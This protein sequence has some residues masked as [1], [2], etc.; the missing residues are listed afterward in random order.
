MNLEEAKQLCLLH[1]ENHGLFEHGFDFKWI[2]SKK[3]FGQCSTVRNRLTKEFVKGRCFIKLSPYLVELNSEEEVEDT[4]LHEIAHALDVIRNGVS[5]GHGY[6]WKKICVEIGAKPVR[7]YKSEH[8]G[9]DI[10]TPKGKYMLI[11]EST[12][13]VVRYYHKKP[14]R[15]FSKLWLKGRKEETYGQLRVLECI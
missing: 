10:K 15:D 1:M 9:G 2:K 4:I 5:S 12:R 6:P 8:N 7:C 3:T 11:V 13:E 14:S